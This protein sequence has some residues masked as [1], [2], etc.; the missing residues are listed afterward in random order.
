MNS[1]P[2]GYSQRPPQIQQP[3]YQ[4]DSHNSQYN[5]NR[6]TT[7]PIHPP[8]NYRPPLLAGSSYHTIQPQYYGHQGSF[9]K[10]DKKADVAQNLSGNP[11]NN[12]QLQALA[13][14]LLKQQRQ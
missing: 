10:E 5:A 2:H 7:A 13:Q 6:S 12:I 11:P 9:P 4:P 3:P 14:M 8:P 1:G